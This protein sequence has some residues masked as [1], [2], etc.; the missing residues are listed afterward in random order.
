MTREV[1]VT[2]IVVQ[3]LIAGFTFYFFYKVLMTKP[4]SDTKTDEG[5]NNS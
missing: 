1:I 5:V 4:K 2:A 3:T